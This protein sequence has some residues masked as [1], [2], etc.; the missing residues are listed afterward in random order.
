MHNSSIT[1]PLATC[2][3]AIDMTAKTT[4]TP[5]MDNIIRM[6]TTSVP[7]GIDNHCSLCISHVPEDFVGNLIPTNRNIKGFLFDGIRFPT[8]SSGT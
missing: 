4:N 1:N 2:L 7:I 5:R 6:D 8:K 3:T